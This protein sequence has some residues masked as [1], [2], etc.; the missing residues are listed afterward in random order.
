MKKKFKKRKRIWTHRLLSNSSFT[1]C[2]TFVG[3][4]QFNRLFREIG[5]YTPRQ[6]QFRRL[7]QQSNKAFKNLQDNLDELTK[8]A[9]LQPLVIPQQTKQ[10][11]TVRIEE[12][13]TLFL[14]K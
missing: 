6:G 2:T 12:T 14:K 3:R 10:P 1:T 7:M 13:P 11:I 8:I 4:G 9:K 5:D